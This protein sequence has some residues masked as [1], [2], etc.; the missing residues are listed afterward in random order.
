MSRIVKLIE[1][2][3]EDLSI[4]EL[5]DLQRLLPVLPSCITP[6]MEALRQRLLTKVGT[7]NRDAF[8]SKTNVRY[9]VTED[10][11]E[12]LNQ[13]ADPDWERAHTVYYIN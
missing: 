1:I 3:I 9:F 5:S 13:A 8:T 4:K 7:V 10:Y 2:T 11:F 12:E 6:Y